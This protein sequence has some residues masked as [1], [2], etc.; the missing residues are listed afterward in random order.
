MFKAERSET[1][2]KFYDGLTSPTGILLTLGGFFTLTS[3]NILEVLNLAIDGDDNA[4]LYLFILALTF[5]AG[6]RLLQSLVLAKRDYRDIESGISDILIFLTVAA[7]TSGAAA[8]AVIKVTDPNLVIILLAIYSA[9]SLVGTLNFIRMYL[10]VSREDTDQFD[11]AIEKPIQMCNVVVFS[12]MTAFLVV[13]TLLLRSQGPGEPLVLVAIASIYPLLLVNMLHSQQL[14]MQPKFLL[15]NNA[16]SPN[17]CLDRIESILAANTTEDDVIEIINFAKP[18]IG[19][20]YRAVKTVRA[21]RKDIDDVCSR[22]IDNFSHVF[23]FVFDNEDALNL[24]KLLARIMRGGSRFNNLGYMNYRYI[25]D[26]IENTKIGLLRIDTPSRVSIYGVYDAFVLPLVAMFSLGT[27]NIFGPLRRARSIARTQTRLSNKEI[28]ITYLI[29]FPEFQK[30]GF[31]CSVLI[32]L[33]NAFLK[34]YTDDYS[35][36]KISLFSRTHNIHALALFKRVG[37]SIVG[38]EKPDILAE[39]YEDVGDLVFMSCQKE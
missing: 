28:R 5:L 22:L 3:R 38:S 24:K 18:K 30:R 13:A 20:G 31:G 39:T 32:L 36:N 33:K 7:F 15:N 29:I 21:Q 12:L 27:V 1:L 35:V 9:C 2:D 10:K 14:T 26:P 8:N 34:N 37:F 19:L 16:D 23:Q 17:T 25:V 11:V 6:F 4:I